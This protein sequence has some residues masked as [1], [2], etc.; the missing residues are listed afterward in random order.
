MKGRV[1][2]RINRRFTRPDHQVFFYDEVAKRLSERLDIVTLEPNVIVA[3]GFGRDSLESRFPRASRIS[4]MDFAYSRMVIQGGRRRFRLPW[5]P[6]LE[7]LCADLSALP[8]SSASVDLV[9]SNLD[10]PFFDGCNE[11]DGLL[12]EVYR[13]LRPG[14]LFIFSSLGPDTLKE[15]RPFGDMR[16]LRLNRH[17]DM[18]DLG[19]RI[20]GVGF[21]DPVMEMEE[22]K[23]TYS[24]AITLLQDVRAHGSEPFHLNNLKGL[25]GKAELIAISERSKLENKGQIMATAELVFGHAWLAPERTSP[26]GQK[27]I[28]IKVG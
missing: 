22:L 6:L 12:K 8:L 21:S 20:M 3:S 4:K 27:I 18:H 9:Y 13:V 14:G 11:L 24:N 25:T 26:K 28:D 2:A 23:L 15:L 16:G 5:R 10:I 1:R 7:N 19:D 17:L